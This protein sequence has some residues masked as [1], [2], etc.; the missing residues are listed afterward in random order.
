M[1]FEQINIPE[2]AHGKVCEAIDELNEESTAMEQYIK[3]MDTKIEEVKNEYSEKT[4]AILKYSHN[5]ESFEMNDR[6][7]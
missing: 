6:R 4:G 1:S 2:F 3:K 7:I 5:K